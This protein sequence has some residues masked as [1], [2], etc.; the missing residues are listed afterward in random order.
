LGR[1]VLA[2]RDVLDHYKN[3]MIK[4]SILVAIGEVSINVRLSQAFRN[5]GFPFFNAINKT[6]IKERELVI[7]EG[8]MIAE[9]TILTCNISVGS[10]VLINVGCTISHD[11]IIGN[12]VNISPGCH[13][14]GRVH[15]EDEV[16]VGT[17]VSFIPK[18]RIG[19]GS[20]IAAG[21]CVTKDVPANCMVAGVPAVIKKYL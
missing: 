3:E 7:G 20:I 13:L 16:F 10:H 9:G 18:V 21:A 14:A 11:C 2:I 1:K 12:Y 4:P 5:A 19:R 8:T 17:G 15:I 6:V